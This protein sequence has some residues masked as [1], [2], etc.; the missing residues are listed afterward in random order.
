MK[1]F[2]NLAQYSG[3]CL[4]FRIAQ[5]AEKWG[6]ED[7]RKITQFN[8]TLPKVSFRCNLDFLKVLVMKAFI[9]P[10]KLILFVGQ[11]CPEFQILTIF[12]K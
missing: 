9:V 5:C 8:E 12:T 7:I 1:E 4:F 3:F 11:F 10:E 2:P 6:R